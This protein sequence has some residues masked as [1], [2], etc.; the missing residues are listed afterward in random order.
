MNGT[1]PVAGIAHVNLRGPEPLVEQLRTFYIDVIGLHEGP[2]PRFRSGSS[3]YWLYAGERDVVHLTVDPKAAEGAAST[4]PH[5][6]FD[7]VAF[8]CRGLADALHRLHEAGID[9]RVD[10]V[11]D[12]HQVQLFLH[13]PA[14]TRIELNFTGEDLPA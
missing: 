8:A 1:P 2:R 13:D 14:G 10:Q 12:L 5:A 9:F 3:G 11:D 7:H 6:G 4:P